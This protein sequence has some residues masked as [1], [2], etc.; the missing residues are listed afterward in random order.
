MGLTYI[1]TAETIMK[2]IQDVKD[3]AFKV[4]CTKEVDL[5]EDMATHDFAIKKFKNYKKTEFLDLDWEPEWK[6]K[7]GKPGRPSGTRGPRGPYNKNKNLMSSSIMRPAMDRPC[8]PKCPGSYG[9][10]PSLQCV[11]CKAMFHAKCQGTVMGTSVLT[12]PILCTKWPNFT[13]PLY[14]IKVSKLKNELTN[15]HVGQKHPFIQKIRSL[16]QKR[17]IL[18]QNGVCQNRCAYDCN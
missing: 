2:A 3:E 5:I 14:Y 11:S 12:K 4:D 6:D 18:T 16:A 13:M 15:V 17:S 8:T 1:A 9:I 7:K 10:L